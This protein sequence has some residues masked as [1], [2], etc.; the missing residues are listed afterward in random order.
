MTL[1]ELISKRLAF[2]LLGLED[3]DFVDELIQD[4]ANIENVG[5]SGDARSFVDRFV[6]SAWLARIITN[7]D[8]IGVAFLEVRAPVGQLGYAVLSRASGKGFATEMA[9]RIVRHA[10]EDLRL[11][12]V[13]ASCSA[14]NT[15]SLRILPVA[16]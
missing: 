2:R 4:P 10:F 8:K 11:L 9:R 1:P 14:Q 3:L 12:K 6:Q 16:M 7:G 15:A 5:T 13:I